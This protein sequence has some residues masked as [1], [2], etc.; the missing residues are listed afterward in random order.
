[1]S[2]K[3]GTSVIRTTQRITFAKIAEL[4]M[5]P[6]RKLAELINRPKS[7]LQRYIKTLARRNKHPES[8]LWETEAGEAWLRRLVFATLYMFGLQRDVGAETLSLFFKLICIDT[9]VG[10]GR[11]L[12][13]GERKIST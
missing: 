1:M 10:V 6:V 13:L 8:M 11:I 3:L 9:H 7:N 2:K 4:G 5:Q 12:T